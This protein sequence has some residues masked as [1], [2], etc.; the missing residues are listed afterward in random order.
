MKSIFAKAKSQANL[1]RNAFDLSYSNKFTASPGMLLPCYVEEVNPNEHFVIRP[2]SFLRTMPL[3]TASFVR[4]KQ[5]I[6]FYFVPMRVLYRQF[7]QFIVGT[8]YSISSISGL[9]SYKGTLPTFKIQEL[10]KAIQAGVKISDSGT[11]PSDITGFPTG[12]GTLR[13]LDLLGYGVSYLIGKQI[14]G[15]T[16]PIWDFS[17]FKRDA[18]VTPFRLLAYQKIYFDFY[19]NSLYELN[20]P[21]AYNIDSNNIGTTI[22]AANVVSR[23]MCTLRYRN[24]KKDY[25]NAV[26]PYFQGADYLTNQ[27]TAPDL[28]QT[29]SSSNL[30]VTSSTSTITSGNANVY[31][32]GN[33][34]SSNF[35]S[36]SFS[37]ANLRS[38][39]ALDKLYRLSIAAG[40]GD[41]GSQIRAHY[42]FNAVH[43]DWKATY[44]GG[45]SEPIQIS[46]VLTTATTEQA[47]TGAISGRGLSANNSGSFTFDTKEHGIIMGIFSVVPECDYNSSMLSTFN[48][49]INR[50]HFFQPEFQ[51]LGLQPVSSFELDFG[52]NA[53]STTPQTLGYINR[54][55]EY[56]TRVDT[57]HGEFQSFYQYAGYTRKNGTLSQWAAPRQQTAVTPVTGVYNAF[58]KIRPNV[59]NN[60]ST[61]AFDGRESTDIFLVDCHFNVSAVRPMSVSGL[62]SI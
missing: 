19:R 3:N 32:F 10:L 58:L 30:K 39:F 41:Y 31:M 52:S 33:I 60:I 29:I 7:Q 11:Y 4:A 2:Q 62:P 9:N 51:D 47:P 43:D 26:S 18:S 38:A 25:F 13:L 12:N 61:V 56:K 8:E 36:L 15:S 5:N 22:T 54:Y 40:D 16:Q 50:E 35:T 45:I 59:F 27:T 28:G 46:E 44:I 48:Q 24:Y 42:G 57:I 14:S 49:K 23:G 1:Q 6:E 55:S 20:N 34:P 17:D 37:I 21:N 53:T